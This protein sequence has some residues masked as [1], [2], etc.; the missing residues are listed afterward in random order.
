MDKN[1]NLDV[2]RLK[3]GGRQKGTPNR[4]TKVLKYQLSQVLTAE[5]E[6]IPELL[7]DL[8][9]AQRL[10]FVIRLSQFVLPTP[11]RGLDEFDLIRLDG[12]EDWGYRPAGISDY[13]ETDDDKTVQEPETC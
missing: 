7:Q 1:R 2:R 12:H 10:N 8:T 13:Y 11:T 9:P 3:T 6:R 5:Y 4:I